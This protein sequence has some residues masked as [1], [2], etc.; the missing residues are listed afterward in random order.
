MIFR[1]D[2]I[3]ISLASVISAFLPSCLLLA[4][5]V[6]SRGLAGSLIRAGRF[7]GGSGAAAARMTTFGRAV[8]VGFAPQASSALMRHSSITIVESG[9][10]TLGRIQA[11]RGHVTLVNAQGQRMLRSEA[12]GNIITHY[13]PLGQPIGY[14]TVQRGGVRTVHR[15]NSGE[16]LGYDEI[17][18]NSVKHFDAS[19][20]YMGSSRLHISGPGTPAEVL[21][22][23]GL[24]ELILAYSASLV[25]KDVKINEVY[26]ELRELQDQCYSYHNEN[27]CRRIKF[28]NGQLETMLRSKET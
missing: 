8:S 2:L 23:A 14:S 1:R 27:A 9:G 21:A 4:R 28:L 11:G 18:E 10:G 26:N 16:N 7:G 25:Y 17:A 19:G 12:Q 24:A 6:V 15:S 22:T 5:L 20:H 13:D 3:S